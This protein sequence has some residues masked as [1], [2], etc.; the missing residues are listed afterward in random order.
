MAWNPNSLVNA[1]KAAGVSYAVDTNWLKVDPYG[2]GF[3]PIGVMW[4]HTACHPL[5]TGNM[6][7]L[8]WCR[9]PGKYAGK[10]RACHIVVGR[11]GKFQ[12]IAGRGAF[13]LGA[14][15]PLKVNGTAMP[16]DQGNRFSIGIEIEASSTT[17]INKKDRVTPKHGMN[18]AQFEAVAKFCAA[19][20]DEFGWSTDA[21]IRHRDWAPGRKIDVGIELAVIREAIDGYR[22]SKPAPPAPKPPV[23]QKPPAPPKPPVAQKP[24]PPAKKPAPPKPPAKPVVRLIDVQPRKKNQSVGIVQKALQKEVGLAPQAT[25]TFNAATKAAYAK[26]QT[27]LGFKGADADGIPGRVSLTKLGRKHGF[28]VKT[29]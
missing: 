3:Q 2:K 20:F 9:N 10:A 18:P 29:T 24:K 8:N 22:K 28:T 16:K 26:W 15:G 23:A 4:H 1:A 7:S 19:L 13:H 21:A 14:G 12:I 5:A 27:K 17:K 11:D 6:P 25:S